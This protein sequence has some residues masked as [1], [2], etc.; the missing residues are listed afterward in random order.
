M[1]L[2]RARLSALDQRRPQCFLCGRKGH[3]AHRTQAAR[4]YLSENH[5][6]KIS[7][8]L[9]DTPGTPINL[10][11]PCLNNKFPLPL[12]SS[13]FELLQGGIIFTKLDLRNTYHLVR[14][15]ERD[16]WKTQYSPSTFHAIWSHQCPSSFSGLG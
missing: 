15:R 14:I 4:L 5:V 2:G 16:E 3:Y 7:F 12:L 6:E 11:Y 9:S 8:F 1:Q 10:S 13:A